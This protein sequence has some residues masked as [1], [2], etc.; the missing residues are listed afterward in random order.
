[1]F[2]E[3]C[4]ETISFLFYSG[5]W[6]SK[7]KVL[8]SAA[9]FSAELRAYFERHEYLFE[10]CLQS[11][12]LAASASWLSTYS[13]QAISHISVLEQWLGGMQK[14]PTSIKTKHRNRLN[15]EQAIPHTLEDSSPN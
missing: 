1:L 5:H 14:H 9:K 12:S 13:S 6:L 3:F 7:R 15:L 10:K 8:P 11:H 2:A 4:E